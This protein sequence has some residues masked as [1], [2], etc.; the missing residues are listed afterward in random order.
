MKKVY[1]IA[2]LPGDGV[3]TELVSAARTVLE[4]VEKKTGSF[5]LNFTEYAFGLKPYTESGQAVPEQTL[6]GLKQSQAA[7]LGAVSVADIP[8]PSPVGFIRKELNLFAD[9]RPIRSLPGAWSLKPGIDLVCI[10]ENTEGFLADRNLYQGYGEFM[11][12]ED[13]VLSMR[14]IS[15]R[16]SENIARFAFRY[17]RANGRKKIT[18]LHKAGVLKLGCGLFLQT[19]K[20]IGREYPEI[21]LTDEYIDNAANNLIAKPE[22]YDILLTTNL[23]GDIIS[24]EAAALVSSIVPTANI[25]PDNAL[26]LPINHS[27]RLHDAGKGVVDPLGMILCVGMLL[28]HLSEPAAGNMVRGAVAESLR[29]GLLAGLSTSGITGKICERI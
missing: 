16:A 27:P 24:D 17:A 1:N 19:V 21:E 28:D 6:T 15:R 26:F 20:D 4:Q 11:P 7:L 22:S 23:F 2:L 13:L 29:E 10:R 12:R 25:G 5:D 8:S 9:V 14:V 3:G 18:V